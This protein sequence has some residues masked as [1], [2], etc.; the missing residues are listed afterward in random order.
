MLSRTQRLALITS[1]YAEKAVQVS[2][3]DKLG[4]LEGWPR[5]IPPTFLHLSCS[6]KRARLGVSLG[7][8]KR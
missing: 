2:L 5:L 8:R 1:L 3:K 6:R 4:E 7:C